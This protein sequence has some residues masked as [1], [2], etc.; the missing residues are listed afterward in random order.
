MP[1]IT[2]RN[3]ELN[4]S[5]DWFK[6]NFIDAGRAISQ[7]VDETYY[8]REKFVVA[9][10]NDRIYDRNNAYI[11]SI[12][13]LN[14]STIIKGRIVDSRSGSGI[15][16]ADIRIGTRI[17]KLLMEKYTR[18]KNSSVSKMGG[19]FDLNLDFIVHPDT[20]AYTP[21]VLITRENY[22]PKKKTFQIKDLGVE[23]DLKKI[24]LDNIPRFLR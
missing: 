16:K 11:F 8:W 23:I 7:K 4:L 22:I 20:L 10:R 14:K 15:I 17:M 5:S 1:G 24:Y 13:L 9:D 21:Y 18:G 19:F 2:L 12:I 6:K 3:I